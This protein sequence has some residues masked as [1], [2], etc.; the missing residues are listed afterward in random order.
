[1]I[2]GNFKSI[3]PRY[4]ISQEASLTWLAK[5]HLRAEALRVG[6]G[7][8]FDEAGFERKI[9]ALLRRHG[10]SPSRIRCRGSEITD[11]T[12]QDWEKMELFSLTRNPEGPTMEERN[13]F[14]QRAAQRICREMFP[15]ADTPPEQVIHVT[16][17]TYVSP[18][19]VQELVVDRG[20]SSHTAVT[21]A[22][23]MGCYAALPATL[24]ARGFLALPSSR[25]G[26]RVDILHTEFCSG[27]LQPADH[28]PEQIVVQSLF[29]DGFIRYSV[30]ADDQD[31]GCRRPGLE[32]L[33]QYEAMVPA[34]REAITWECGGYGMKM[35]LSRDVPQLITD[36]LPSFLT[37]LASR[38][39]TSPAE[40]LSGA[41]FAIHP[42]GPKIID[43]IQTL[44]HLT[45]AQVS[46]SRAILMEYGNMSSATLPHVW[47]AVAADPGVVSGTRVVSL[48][49]GPGLSI[50]GAVL[51]KRA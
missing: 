47:A 34:T 12:H 7:E 37:E 1:M 23:H 40:L 19:C 9:T 8:P 26:R 42:G 38:S 5:A 22:Y 51:V 48:A 25:T 18:S 30:F 17:T 44:C 10:C 3:R 43:Q 6:T 32:I 49:F 33:G 13:A 39:G 20:W 31:P 29:A 16:C 50:S 15:E 41:V 4:Q 27:H 36:H 46:F 11:F 35:G 21:H 45:D 28:S 14:F 24:M 2:V